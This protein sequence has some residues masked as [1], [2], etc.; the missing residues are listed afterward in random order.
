MPRYFFDIA[1]GDRVFR[2]AEGS[3][4]PD[5]AAAKREGKQALADMGRDIIPVGGSDTNLSVV[6][7]DEHGREVA[8][9]SLVFSTR[10][11]PPFS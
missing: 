5:D 9:M 3:E 2:D 7:R 4:L 11:R 1:D 6:I 10:V 8:S